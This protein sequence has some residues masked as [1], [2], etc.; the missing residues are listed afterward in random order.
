MA[1]LYADWL[2][3]KEEE[4]AAQTRRREIEDKLLAEWGNPSEAGVKS[5]EDD[6]Y[7]V[8]VTFRN[9]LKVDAEKM[10]DIA[11]EKGLESHLGDLLR[12]KA[13]LNKKTWDNASDE[14]TGPLAEAVTTTPGRPSFS[15]ESIIY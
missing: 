7:K 15:I 2:K 3:A 10:R 9:S 14:I 8:K 13:E 6:G 5:F 11:F 12:W 1:N 4:K